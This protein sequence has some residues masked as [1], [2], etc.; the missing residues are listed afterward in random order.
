MCSIREEEFLCS[1]G[2]VQS[3]NSG[4]ALVF[5]LEFCRAGEL[6]VF[7]SNNIIRRLLNRLQLKQ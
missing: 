5:G 1:A 4:I 7:E 6:V 3:V 2:I